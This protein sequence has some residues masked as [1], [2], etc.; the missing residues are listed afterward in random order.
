MKKHVL[1]FIACTLFMFAIYILTFNHMKRG[2]KQELDKQNIDNFNTISVLITAI[3]NE[4]NNPKN[5]NDILSYLNTQQI[6]SL[7]GKLKMHDFDKTNPEHY[8]DVLNKAGHSIRRIDPDDDTD[9]RVIEI[10]EFLKKRKSPS[11]L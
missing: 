2:Y 11:P 5:L 9:P 8:I 1:F 3:E 4:K 7:A 6:I 10:K